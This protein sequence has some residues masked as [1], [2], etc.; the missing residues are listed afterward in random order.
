MESK[1]NIKI[2]DRELAC[3]PFNSSEGQDYYKAMQCGVNM[4][5]ANRQV[6][7]HRL[8]E[9]FSQIFKKSPEDLE[10]KQV[11]DVSHNRA[12]IEKHEVDGK[13]KKLIVHRKGSTGNYYPGREEIPKLYRNLGSPVII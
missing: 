11:W 4:S 1:Y 13:I 10:I 6:I 5:F 2:L 12:S 9:V 3:A 7:V 8:R